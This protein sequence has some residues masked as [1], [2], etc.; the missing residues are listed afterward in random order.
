MN[1]AN[2]SDLDLTQISIRRKPSLFD[3]LN[4]NRFSFKRKE[5]EGKHHKYTSIGFNNVA[6]YSFLTSSALRGLGRKTSDEKVE[7][8]VIYD[9][10]ADD[11]C[12]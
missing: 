9:Y 5:R 12:K 4:L 1:N 2:F 10:L 6:S 8:V 3:K 7:N 11:I